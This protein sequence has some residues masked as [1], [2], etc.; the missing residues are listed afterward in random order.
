M[1]VSFILDTDAAPSFV[2]ISYRKMHASTNSN[3]NLVNG[4]IIIQEFNLSV[5]MGLIDDIMDIVSP[6]ESETDEIKYKVNSQGAVKSL[7]A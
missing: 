5:N 1:N 2:I 3:V 7:K 4:E 6:E